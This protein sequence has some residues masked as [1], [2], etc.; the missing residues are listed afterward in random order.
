[1]KKPKTSEDNFLRCP[2]SI[3]KNLDKLKDYNNEPRWH[4]IY[5][6]IENHKEQ[7]K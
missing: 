3:Q 2:Q 5:R 1:M 7:M 6:L 4:V